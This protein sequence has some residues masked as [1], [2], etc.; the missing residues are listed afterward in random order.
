MDTFV[1]AT[2]C[3]KESLCFFPEFN[4]IV[5]LEVIIGGHAGYLLLIAL[6]RLIMK[7]SG[8]LTLKGPML[9]Y[10]LVQVI[11]SVTMTV[12]LFPFLLNNVFN[13]NGLFC[14]KIEFWVLVHFVTKFLDMFDSI[15]MVLRKKEEQLSFLHVYHHCTIGFI[16]G[17]LLHFGT[18]NGTAFFGAWINS[19]V[20]AMMYFHYFWTSLGFRNPFKK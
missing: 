5:S 2:K 15:F 13:I 17:L 11:A 8:P 19:L 18:A 14:S 12:A 3:A 6:L 9:L 10:N 20:H 4:Y 16:W 1:D 7:N